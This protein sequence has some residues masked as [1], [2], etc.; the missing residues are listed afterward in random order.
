MLPSAPS[1]LCDVTPIF[2]LTLSMLDNIRIITGYASHT[3]N[4]GSAA[5]AMKTMGIHDLVLVAPDEAPDGRAW[6]W[7]LAPWTFWPRRALWPPCLRRW[8]LV[9]SSV[10]VRPLP[11]PGWPM[12]KIRGKLGRRR[13]SMGVPAQGS[14]CL[15]T[16]AYRTDQRRVAAVSLP[17]LHSGQSGIQLAQ[18]RHG[19]TD[20]LL[21][22]TCMPWR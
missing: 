8:P 10:P 18:Y 16:R 22:I 12:R 9:W 4:I 5:R 11:D 21:R 2:Q 19:G 17:C 1:C 15:R 3:G 14:F 6:P 13:P 7:L 20:P